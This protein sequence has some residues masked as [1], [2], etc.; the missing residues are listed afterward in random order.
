MCI[1]VVARLPQRLKSVFFQKKKFFTLLSA[2][3]PLR[4]IKFQKALILAFD[5]NNAASLNYNFFCS[6]FTQP[7]VI[8]FFFLHNSLTHKH[9]LLL[10]SSMWMTLTFLSVALPKGLYLEL[11]LVPLL[12]VCSANNSKS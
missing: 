12:D 5:V 4:S 6:D 9:R 7:G 1:R 8:F 2:S 11:W 3:G 10:F